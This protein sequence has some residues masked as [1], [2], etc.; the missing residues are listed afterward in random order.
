MLKRG[1]G[2]GPYQGTSSVGL[3]R[4][5]MTPSSLG[6]DPFSGGVTDP[7][8]FVDYVR[9]VQSGNP[10]SNIVNQIS[11]DSSS[12]LSLWENVLEMMRD[13]EMAPPT[14]GFANRDIVP[15]EVIE[16][17]ANQDLAPPTE[18]FA[19]SAPIG[20]GGEG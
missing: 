13:Q 20:D 16:A 9:G 11:I 17:V 4:H 2:G 3:S 14:E 8:G 7:Q 1:G 12:S 18:G 19:R 10:Q 15:P 6:M 5:L